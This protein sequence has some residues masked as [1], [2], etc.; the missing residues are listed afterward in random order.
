[1]YLHDIWGKI[2]MCSYISY[3]DIETADVFKIFPH[4][5][6][7]AYYSSFDIIAADIHVVQ[8]V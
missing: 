7:R 5:I 8:Y 2:N 4:G 6:Q 1:M 3:L